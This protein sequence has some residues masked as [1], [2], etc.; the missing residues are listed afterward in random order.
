MAK[1]KTKANTEDHAGNLVSGAAEVSPAS[2]APSRRRSNLATDGGEYRVVK[3]STLTL[4]D[5]N[6]R[7]IDPYARRGLRENVKRVGIVQYPVWNETTGRIVAGHQRISILDEE[8]QYDPGTRKNDYDIP[9]V[10]VRWDEKTEKEQNI[11][12]NNQNITGQWDGARLEAM[13]IDPS[14]SYE[15]MG[16]NLVSAELTLQSL[17]RDPQVL[18]ALLAPEDDTG[19]AERQQIAEDAENLSLEAAAEVEAE[20]EKTKI[21]EIKEA[22]RRFAQR[23]QYSRESVFFFIMA[24][25]TN[26]SCA[27]F[28]SKTGLDASQEVQYGPRLAEAFGIRLDSLDRRAA[29]PEDSQEQESENSSTQNPDSGNSEPEGE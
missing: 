11:A 25:P 8:N 9:V 4:A 20:L 26:E 23:S 15:N 16:F 18:E 17:G 28:L 3:R 22:K 21:A 27:E 2:P 13:L 5:Y 19:E 7:V 12:L 24:F 6:P 1:R 14:L 29:G 10:V